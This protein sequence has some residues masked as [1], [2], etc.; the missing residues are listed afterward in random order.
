MRCWLN[1][2]ETVNLTIDRRPGSEWSRLV[3]ERNKEDGAAGTKFELPEEFFKARTGPILLQDHG[4]RVSFRNIR[5]RRLA[6]GG[7]SAK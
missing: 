2:T 6:D 7:R 4:N 5:I 1:G 3:E